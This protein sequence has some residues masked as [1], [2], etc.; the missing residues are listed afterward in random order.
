MDG[1]RICGSG[2]QKLK[3]LIPILCTGDDT[4][5]EKPCYYFFRV[6]EDFSVRGYAMLVDQLCHKH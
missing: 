2:C 5:I 6:T 3:I 1:A 4:I